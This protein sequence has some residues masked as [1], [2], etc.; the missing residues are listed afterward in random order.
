M[1]I[2]FSVLFPLLLLLVLP[3]ILRLRSIARNT[4]TNS[5]ENG[6]LVLIKHLHLPARRRP[7]LAVQLR[8]TQTRKAD[9]EQLVLDHVNNG[10]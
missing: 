9:V 8:T 7:V 3:L 6:P 2:P 1:F 10:P 5:S 4:Q